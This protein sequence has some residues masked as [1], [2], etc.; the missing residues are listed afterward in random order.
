MITETEVIK[1]YSDSNYIDDA[2][3]IIGRASFLRGETAIAES[4]FKELIRDYSESQFHLRAKIWLLYT[5]LRMGKL[6]NIND[7]IFEIVNT[8]VVGKEELYLLNNI[9]AEFYI[10]KDN[11]DSTYYYYEKA[12]DI[13]SIES[14]KISTYGKLILIAENNQDKI[15]ASK[16][17][18]ALDDIAPDQMRIDV[19]MKWLTYQRELGNYEQIIVC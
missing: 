9:N 18:V 3:F 11:L 10:E 13:T 12:I 16:Y 1:K 5:H 17:L 15:Q 7:T 19:R 4:Y 8:N 14:K 6:N 2:L